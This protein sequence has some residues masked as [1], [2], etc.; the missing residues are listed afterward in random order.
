MA[1]HLGFSGKR[2]LLARGMLWSG[3]SFLL[4]QIPPRDSLMV[5]TYHRIGNRYDD[6]FDPG[7]ISATSDQFYEQISYLK[8]KLSLV[9]LE[10]ALA[11]VDGTIKEK[12]RRCRVL[13]T[14]D[15]G[16]LDNYELA[17]PILYTHDVQGV[18]FLT[19]SRVGTS[20]VPWWDH[21]AFLIKTA[22]QRRF[23]L[24][25]P[26][27]HVV[28]LEKNG[29]DISMRNVNYLYSSSENV[30]K[31][32]FIREL[33]EESRGEELPV[34]FRRYLNWDEARTMI[35]GGMAI[36]SHTHTHPILSR[37]GLAEQRKELSESRNL[38]T[39][40]LGIEVDT[41]AYPYGFETSFS[42][43]SQNLL[44][45]AGYHAA[46]SFYGGTNQPGMMQRYDIKRIEAGDQSWSCFRVRSVVC[47]LTGNYWP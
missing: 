29:M 36:G 42:I 27:N 32:R 39:A 37:L 5:L 40:Q 31:V 26:T 35:N 10:E 41:L 21:I 13:I 38:L 23:T 7:V 47:R 33:K 8:R 2:D 15:D 18:F 45:E 46:F 16:Y 17:F 43:Q 19:T 44:Q 9:S 28:D 11:F 6:P 20:Y 22:R 34:A 25:Y 14:F 1:R 30:D 12:T 3:A 4:S 24:H